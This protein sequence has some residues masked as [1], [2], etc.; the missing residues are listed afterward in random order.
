[1]QLDVSDTGVG[2]AAADLPHIF[3]PFQRGGQA[4]GSVEGAGIG[5]AV[6][7]ALVTLMGGDIGA[8]S[9][10]GAGSVFSVRLPL[11]H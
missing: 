5:L 9:T 3:E 7:R 2:I 10:S 8:I 1:V 11:G 6:T 4:R